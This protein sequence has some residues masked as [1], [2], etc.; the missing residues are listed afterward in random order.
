MASLPASVVFW[1]DEVIKQ[2]VE[3]GSIE[4]PQAASGDK[5]LMPGK[6]VSLRSL[7]NKGAARGI[8]KESPVFIK[9]SSVVL[10][11]V[12]AV[13]LVRA[14]ARKDAAHTIGLS[15]LLGGSLSNTKDR[16]TRGYVVDYFSFEKGPRWLKDLVFNL[17]DMAIF[18]GAA[19][20]SAEYMKE[21]KIEVNDD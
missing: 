17:S 9:T 20:A 12:A 11:I 21:D 4:M 6:M 5:K 15:L 10:S 8:G 19:M 18:A 1:T 2:K 14:A 3:E 7:H 16:M 13:L